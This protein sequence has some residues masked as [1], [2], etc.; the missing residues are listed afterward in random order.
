[1]AIY[2]SIIAIHE[3]DSLRLKDEEAAT[4]AEQTA[5]G[6]RLDLLDRWG[7][8]LTVATIVLGLALAS[9]YIYSGWVASE[10]ISAGG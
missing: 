9:A 7:K 5:L 2:R 1:M 8:I 3:D 6:R 4:V 10:R